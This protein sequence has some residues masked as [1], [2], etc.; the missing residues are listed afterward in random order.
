VPDQ[1]RQLTAILLK[2]H[3]QTFAKELGI[4]LSRNAPSALFRLLC[5]ALLASSRISHT[6]AI[7]AAR[8]LSRQKWNTAANMAAATWRQRTDVLNDAGYARYDESTSR[9]LGDT[10]QLLLEQYRGD[11]R[12]LREEARRDP[13][14]ERK[15][16][17]QFKGIGDVG[18]DIFFREIQIVWDEVYPHA[19]RRVLKAAA[20]LDLGNDAS[21]L[22]RLVANREEFARLTAALVRID[23]TNAYE[24][25]QR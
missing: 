7:K 5:F 6:I 24:L 12:K 15:L 20:K 8:A 14:A 22:K 17:K 4:D 1:R 25:A 13:S 3:G 23:L 18:A 9:M 2:R 21:A 11:L 10:A 19:D 16:L